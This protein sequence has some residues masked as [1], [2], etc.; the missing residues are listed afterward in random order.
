M[1]KWKYSGKEISFDQVDDA[2]KALDNA[3]LHCGPDKH[4][5]ECPIGKAKAELYDIKCSDKRHIPDA[6]L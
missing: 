3:C 2:L 6:Q 5:P 1:T 4:S